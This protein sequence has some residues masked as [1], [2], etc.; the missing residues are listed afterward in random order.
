ML[1]NVER[2]LKMCTCVTKL[3]VVRPF[4]YGIGLGF[5]VSIIREGCLKY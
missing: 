5:E 3:N 4:L 2:E 1:I